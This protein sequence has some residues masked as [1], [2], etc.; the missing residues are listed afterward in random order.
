MAKK[1]DG[2]MTHPA[3]AVFALMD[4]RNFRYSIIKPALEA[5]KAALCRLTTGKHQLRGFRNISRAPLSLL[6]PVISD[7][8]NVATE[9]AEKV[10]RHW[11]AAQGEL[12]EAVGARLTELGYDIKDDAFDEEGLIQWASLKK[13]HADLQY[14]G[15]FLEELDSNA[16]MLMSLLLGWF[17][18]DDEEDETE[19]EESN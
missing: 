19:E 11:F 17:G 1:D 6:L 13:E 8:A 5:D 10:L 18:G 15:K 2:T 7:E 9:L 4:D 12:R 16:V 3:N 14:D